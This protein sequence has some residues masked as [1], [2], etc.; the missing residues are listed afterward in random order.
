MF[1]EKKHEMKLEISGKTEQCQDTGP[2]PA[3]GGWFNGSN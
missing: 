1:L 3:K 2:S